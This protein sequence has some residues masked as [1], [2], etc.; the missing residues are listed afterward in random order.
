MIY[1]ADKKTTLLCLGDSITY[2]QGLLDRLRFHYPARLEETGTFK[3]WN[4]GVNGTTLNP[5][6][7]QS[8]QSTLSY[9]TS[10][11]TECDWILLVIGTNDSKKENRLNAEQFASFYHALLDEIAEDHPKSR[12]IIG[13]P[14]PAFSPLYGINNGWI[15]E[16]VVPSVR[17]IATIRHLPLNDLNLLFEGRRDCFYDGIHPN[18]KGTALIAE[19]FDTLLCK[20][21]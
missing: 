7:L 4:F 15:N 9:L 5:I 13:T 21:M 18:R 10:R 16:V 6:S 2:G 8:Y 3:T 1:E 12:I 19:S 11:E 14:P 20:L 17:D